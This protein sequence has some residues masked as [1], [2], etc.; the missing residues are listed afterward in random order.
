MF[1]RFERVRRAVQ[2]AAFASLYRF[3]GRIYDPFTVFL[4]GQGWGRWR[5]AVLAYLEDGPILDLGCG[6]GALAEEL[7]R[8]G[9]EVVGLDLEPSMLARANRRVGLHSRLVR[10]N[11]MQLPFRTA[12]FASC[13]TTFPANYILRTA[14]LNEIARVLRPGGIFAVVMSGYTES[15][16]LWRQPIRLALR[17]FYGSREYG[18]LPEEKFFEHPL[19]S[20][21]WHW[22]DNGDDHVLIWLGR[23]GEID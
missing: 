6:T 4:F 18:R 21:E 3:G 1:R 8:R 10:G 11:A 7:V 12:A 9:N 2:R 23:R 14:T 15:W 5:T 22:L 16:P 19:L 17:L 20:G 13:V